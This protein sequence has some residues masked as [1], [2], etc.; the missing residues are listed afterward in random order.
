LIHLKVDNADMSP[1]GLPTHAVG[2]EPRT[3][4]SSRSRPLRAGH[5]GAL[6]HRADADLTSVRVSN[7]FSHQ[8]AALHVEVESLVKSA[9][10]GGLRRIREGKPIMEWDSKLRRMVATPLHDSCL[11][12]MDTRERAERLVHALDGRA[13]QQLTILR[14]ALV[15]PTHTCSKPPEPS[16][17]GL[18]EEA[19]M[20]KALRERAIT[21]F[22]PLPSAAPHFAVDPRVASG[23]NLPAATHAIPCE[24]VSEDASSVVSSGVGSVVSSAARTTLAVAC[25]FCK[26]EGHF[27]RRLDGTPSCPALVR[28]LE[29]EAARESKRAAASATAP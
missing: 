7:I 23:A 22:P 24:S 16:M 26:T 3:M 9:R 27:A 25:R 12:V 28:K 8:W 6:T 21:T 1:L 2:R 11:V 29:C 18:Y 20:E 17:D 5:G 10:I 19:H 15:K 14:A 4:S 13:T